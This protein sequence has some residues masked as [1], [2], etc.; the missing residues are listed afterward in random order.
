MDA[1]GNIY[2]TG[3]HMTS[4]FDK[5]LQALESLFKSKD[6]AQRLVDTRIAI[7]MPPSH[8][9]KAASLLSEFLVDCL[10]DRKSVV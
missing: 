5:N 6:L 7:V 3:A 8:P 10:A 9:P 2:S 4:A 1:V